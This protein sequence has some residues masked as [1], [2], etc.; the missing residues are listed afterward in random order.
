MKLRLKCYIK[1]SESLKAESETFIITPCK[2]QDFPTNYLT[3]K[4]SINRQFLQIFKH[5]LVLLCLKGFFIRNDGYQNKL[6]YSPMLGTV[7]VKSF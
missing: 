1:P 2:T 5:M 7:F 3:T 6:I 4:C